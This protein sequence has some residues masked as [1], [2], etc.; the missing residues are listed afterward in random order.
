MRRE[1]STA[2]RQ[3][4]GARAGF[5]CSNPSCRRLT[6]GPHTDPDKTIDVGAI[7]HIT[8]IKA[9]GP[10]YDQ[11]LSDEQRLGQ[12]NLL[13]LCHTCAALIDYDVAK[14]SVEILR[15][16]KSQAEKTAAT[17]L[18][19]FEDDDW[20]K[21]IKSQCKRLLVACDKATTSSEKGKA[22]EDLMDAMFGSEVGLAVSDRRVSTC[23]EEID[24]VLM[25]NVNR[26]FWLALN[27]P[28]LFV[29]CKNWTRHIGT[30]DVRDFEVKLQNHTFL[31]KVGVFVSINGFSSEVAS[32]LKRM[33]RSNY[34]VVMIERADIVAYLDASEGVLSW[35]EKRICKLH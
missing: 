15:A 34:H 12:E 27:S 33:S 28:L 24:L 22:L 2:L 18:T 31:V 9:Y 17:A 35:L 29:E 32:E 4:V 25:N 6:F 21:D 14:Y 8:A 23:D 13:W 1:S 11:S 5:R 16:W 3:I 10:R 19:T 20:P 7:A 26:P 30:K